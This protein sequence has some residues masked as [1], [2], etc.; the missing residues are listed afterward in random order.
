[1]ETTNLLLKAVD[2]LD[3]RCNP[4][5]SQL[6]GGSSG[7]S[8]STSHLRGGSSGSSNLGASQESTSR[9]RGGSSGLGAGQELEISRL[10]N[11]S[12]VVAR[13]RKQV[14]TSGRSS[15]KKK[16]YMYIYAHFLLFSTH[17]SAVSTLHL[18]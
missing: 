16:L 10:F 9:L 5:T 18:C 1:M 4:S 6:R 14:T 12:G 17:Y 11:W 15:K 13:K 8:P 2:T 3:A 7:S